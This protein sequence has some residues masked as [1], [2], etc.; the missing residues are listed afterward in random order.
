MAGAWDV[1]CAPDM[2]VR[3]NLADPAY[4]PSDDELIGLMHDAFGGLK[5]AREA[6]LLEMRERI[7]PVEQEARARLAAFR[8]VNARP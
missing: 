1:R 3:R 7:V 5:E 4:E 6:S 2:A 8:Q